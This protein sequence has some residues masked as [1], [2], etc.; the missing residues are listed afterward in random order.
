LDDAHKRFVVPGTLTALNVHPGTEDE[1][2]VI[3]GG[4]AS[5][6]FTASWLP[7]TAE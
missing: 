6:R 2:P 5:T 3:M 4:E 7:G 1:M